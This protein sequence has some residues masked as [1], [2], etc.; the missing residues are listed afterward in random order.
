V[1]HD[2]TLR[3]DGSIFGGWQQVNIDRGIEQIAG[4]FSIG[5]TE[6]W[7]GQNVPREILPGASCA[8][9][10][11]SDI[12]ITGYVDTVSSNLSESGHTLTI[13]GRDKTADLVDCAAIFKTGQWSGKKLERIVNDI[14]TPFGVSL[15]TDIDTGEK[16]KTFQIQE[17]ETAFECIERAARMRSALLVSDGRGGL[18]IT[19]AGKDMINASIEVGENVKSASAYYDHSSRY[20]EYTVKASDTGDDFT[21][22]EQNAEPKG[23]AQDTHIK[24]YRPMISIAED[25]ADSKQCKQRAEWERNIRIGRSASFEYV[26]NDWY[27]SAGLWEPN[28]LITVIDKVH[29][30]NAK[31]LIASVRY[32][33]DESGGTLTS[34]RVTRPDAYDVEPLIPDDDLDLLLL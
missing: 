31:L 14:V 24:R 13:T 23:V 33:I 17:S 5:L 28:K 19:R 21:T 2:V 12:V 34:L 6:K 29:G 1:R 27:N 18:V 3:I 10:I 7:P 8:V 16:L 4:S 9:L 22:P 15:K 30:I 26:V 20:S 25:N 32:S 11:N